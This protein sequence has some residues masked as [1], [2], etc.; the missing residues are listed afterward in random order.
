MSDDRDRNRHF[1]L[2]KMCDGKSLTYV[3][4][5]EHIIDSANSKF[6]ICVSHLIHIH[7]KSRSY[8]YSF[9]FRSYENVRYLDF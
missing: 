9:A 1:L 2:S 5:Y 4:L 8:L 7:T 3:R 6:A